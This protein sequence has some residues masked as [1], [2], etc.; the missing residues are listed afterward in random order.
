MVNFPT[1]TIELPSKGLFYPEGHPLADGRIEL[2]YMTAKHEDILTSP[3]L[4]AKGIN[5]VADALL[6]ELIA[7]PGVN[8]RDLLIGDKNAMFIA[9]RIL[10]YGKN[11]D[12]LMTCQSCGESSEE[13]INL[14]E[15]NSIDVQLPE[16]HVR[17]N[18]FEFV[19]PISKKTVKFKLLTQGDETDVEREL[20]DYEKKVGGDISH[21]ATARLRR[22]ILA[23]DDN[24]D[25]AVINQFVQSMPI[26]DSRALREHARKFTPDID[27]SLPFTCPKCGEV[28][29]TEVQV[30]ASF[31]WPDLRV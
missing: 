11:Y 2:Y 7:T 16:G 24:S 20:Q 23:V 8:F 1:E 5:V 29:K 15:L 31:F 22:A 18:A 13:T 19:L 25:K 21:G 10:G 9:S 6:R 30:D 14:E 28:A 26:R 3:N 27:M 12:C 17:G 4:I